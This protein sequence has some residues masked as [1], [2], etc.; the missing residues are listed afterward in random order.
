ME[1]YP[2]SVERSSLRETR[3]DNLEKLRREEGVLERE[4]KGLKRGDSDAEEDD[5]VAHEKPV[6]STSNDVVKF[7]FGGDGFRLL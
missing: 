4:D 6:E 5:D 7:R 2:T 3:R 1:T